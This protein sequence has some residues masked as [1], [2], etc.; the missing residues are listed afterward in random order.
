L[1]RRDSYFEGVAYGHERV[2]IGDSENDRV[3]AFKT[4][5]KRT[6]DIEIESGIYG[7]DIVF[8][9]DFV[10]LLDPFLGKLNRID[11][12]AL[13]LVNSLPIRGYKRK[14][15][16]EMEESDLSVGDGFAWATDPVNGTVHKID[17]GGA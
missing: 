13:K 10:L 2:W 5:T 3:I 4:A 8:A 7:D 15:K 14:D 6:K 16:T 11:T 9:E 12:D 17:Y 1:R